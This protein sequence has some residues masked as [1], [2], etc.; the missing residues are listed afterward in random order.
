MANVQKIDPKHLPMKQI[1][2]SDTI[3]QRFAEVL[4]DRAPQ[5]LSSIVSVVNSNKDL[6]KVDQTSVLNAAM[7]AATLNLPIN[8]NLGFF[9]I[10][11]YGSIAQAQMGYKGYIQLAQRSGLYQRLTA[12]PVYQDE[13][14]GW[15]PLT[16][17]LG[18]TPNF[19]DRAKNEKP[20]GYVAYF[21]LTNGFKKTVYWTWKQVDDHRKKF[22]KSGGS[23]DQPKGVWASNYD[24]MALKTVITNLLTKWGPMTTDIQRAVDIDESDASD[25]L[26]ANEAEPKDV[27]PGSS[28]EQFLGNTDQQQA[29]A[30]TNKYEG[31]TQNELK[32]DITHDPNE[33]AEQTSL[34]D[35]GLP[36][37]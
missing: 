4:K 2:Q 23:G 33:H 1:I 25:Q 6:S 21:Q 22:S 31:V 17:E 13:F 16:E 10:V 36:F 5:F 37:K 14:G 3:K 12:V 19:E 35:D 34:T 15:N 26:N 27:T 29:S 8:Q 28:L 18:Y 30:S 7:T 9:Y 20:V 24:A 11:P 32:P